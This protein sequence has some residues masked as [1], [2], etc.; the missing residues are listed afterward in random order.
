MKSLDKFFAVTRSSAGTGFDGQSLYS[1]EVI[2]G[3]AVMTKIG[4][5]GSSRIQV[6]TKERARIIIIGKQLEAMNPRRLPPPGPVSEFFEGRTDPVGNSARII[7][8]FLD[9]GAA[10]AAFDDREPDRDT[11]IR[12]YM[13]QTHAVLEMIGNDHD[14]FKILNHPDAWPFCHHEKLREIGAFQSGMV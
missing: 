13:L 7:G 6:G 2:E 3:N 1:L 8:L 5:R 11:I 12:K 4:L 9:E 10:R 14:Q